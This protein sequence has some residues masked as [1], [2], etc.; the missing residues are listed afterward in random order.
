MNTYV[1]YYKGKTMEVQSDTTYHAQLE[2]ARLFKAK[3]S[4]MVDVMLAK[5]NGEPVVHIAV[6]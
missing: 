3:K 4:Y 6:N 5:K 2:G 1:C